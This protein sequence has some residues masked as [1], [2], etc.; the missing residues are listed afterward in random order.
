MFF[1]IGGVQP[2]T[3][4]MDEQPRMCP[5][6]GLYQARLKRV[7]H[8]ISVFFLPIFRVKKGV[9]FILCDRCG[10]ISSES[11]EGPVSFS[12]FSNLSICP[13]CG[14]PLDSKFQYCPFCGKRL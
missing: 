13:N 1:F 6:C 5:A 9:P 11:G 12:E 4:K 3:I 7:D 2:K 10:K 14:K 8:Y